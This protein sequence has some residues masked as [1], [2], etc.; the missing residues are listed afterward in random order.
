MLGADLAAPRAASRKNRT[1]DHHRPRSTAAVAEGR[2]LLAAAGAWSTWRS[3]W[4]DEYEVRV[5]CACRRGRAR[6]P[7]PGSGRAG[8][9]T[10]TVMGWETEPMRIG[11]AR[12]SRSPCATWSPATTAR[13]GSSANARATRLLPLAAAVWPPAASRPT[14]TRSSSDSRRSLRL[15]PVPQTSEQRASWP[16]GRSPSSPTPC[17]TPRPPA[18]T[19][20]GDEIIQIGA[21]RIVNG[22]LRREPST[23]WSTRSAR[24]PRPA[25]HPRHHAGD[26]AGQPTI[27]AGAAGLPRL[28]A[29]HRAGGAQ[30]RLRHA[31]PEL[32]EEL[33]RH[34]P[35]TSRCSTRCGRQRVL[36]GTPRW[37]MRW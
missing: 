7:R 8:M 12:R 11:G 25:S 22:K 35:S 26:G 24:F 29:G 27:A 37:A 14:G 21:T 20:A 32:K 3:G 4:S 5:R 19:P 17:S 9:S 2:Q 33:H 1:A 6:A 10:E 18:S 34:R 16:S 36:A 13:S 23:S 31:L 30:R 28:R 15:R